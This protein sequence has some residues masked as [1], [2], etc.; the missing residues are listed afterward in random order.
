MYIYERG[1]RFVLGRNVKTLVEKIKWTERFRNKETK[2]KRPLAIKLCSPG[3]L[4]LVSSTVN[5][6]LTERMALH[7][8]GYFLHEGLPL[9]R[10]AISERRRP[11]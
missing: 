5:T 3:P 10:A 4:T 8:D 1:K 2:T 11:F 9:L 6:Y 7:I